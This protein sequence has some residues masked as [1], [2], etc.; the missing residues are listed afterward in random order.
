MAEIFSKISENI[1]L[2]YK[3]FSDLTTAEDWI[4]DK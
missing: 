4:I 2:N 1:P 3:V